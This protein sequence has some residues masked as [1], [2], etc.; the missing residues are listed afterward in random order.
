M[1][2]VRWI[3]LAA[4]SVVLVWP[5]ESTAQTHLTIGQV[6]ARARERAPAVVSAR[7]ALDEARA[8]IAVASL[9]STTNP[10][11]DFNIGNRQRDGSRS[12]DLD[13]GAAQMFDPFGSRTARM[14]GATAALDQSQAVLDGTIREAQRAAAGAFYQ[15]VYSTERIRLLTD[16]ERLANTT[17]QIAE[18]RLT[19][20]DIAALDVNL[21]RI[22]AARAKSE[23]ELAES[24]QFS[25]TGRLRILLA[26]DGPIAVDDRLT[27]PSDADRAALL[28]A[29]S[30]RSEVREIEAAIREAEADVNLGRAASRPTYGIEFRFKQEDI[31]RIA[32][33]GLRISLPVFS[34]GQE[35]R[36][37][38]TARAQRLRSDLQLARF[39]IGIEVDAAFEAYQRRLQAVRSLET[40]ALAILNDS[41]SLATRSFEAGQISLA[42]L[43]LSRREILDTRFQYLTLILEAALARVDLDAIAAVLR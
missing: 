4:A 13:I 12:T 20:G 5:C 40:G 21:A 34:K 16:G 38:G 28:D 7:L 10:E 22:A 9:R 8:R 14:A 3:T 36:A 37:S 31:D 18:R 25:A 17:L 32:M 30:R 15:L 42:D 29:A 33:G 39:R 2:R 23:R 41:D 11:F 35:L 24:E 1:S 6:L 26:L 27:L 43:L 19:A